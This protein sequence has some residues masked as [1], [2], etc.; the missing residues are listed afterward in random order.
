MIPAIPFTVVTPGPDPQPFVVGG[1]GPANFLQALDK[2]EGFV[3]DK[4]ILSGVGDTESGL[5]MEF[6]RIFEPGVS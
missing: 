5:R 3:K 4:V 6:L 2:G 1:S